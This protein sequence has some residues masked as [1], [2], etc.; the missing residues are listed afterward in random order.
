M[1]TSVFSK[2]RSAVLDFDPI[3]YAGT[4]TRVQ[5]MLVESRGPQAVVG[6]LCHIIMPDGSQ[7]YA[8]VVGLFGTTVQL[9][10]FSDVDGIELG[11]QVV[12]TGGTMKIA[13][14]DD[15]LGRVVDGLG[16]TIDGKGEVADPELY[17]VI[18]K[19][20][21]VLDR[22]RITQQI[23]TGIRAL[24]GLVPAG[25]GQR[26]GIFSG[27]GVGKSTLLGMIARNTNADVNVIALIGE[28]GREVREFIEQDLGPDGLE[29]SV[30]V[31]STSDTPAIARVRGAFVAMAVAE[32]FRD[33]KKDVML[34]F[35]SVTRFAWAQREIGLARGEAP[36]TRGY[37]PSVFSLLPR[38]L[39][40]CGTS[41]LGTITGFFTV[42]VEGDDLEEPV[43]DAVRGIL[44][45][46]VVL[47]R[48]LAQR[49][50][51]PAIDVLGSVSRL[52]TK[53]SSRPVRDAAGYVRR[54]LAIYAD[55]EDLITAG[56]Y[57]PG[58]SEEVDEA[59]K[60]LPRINAFLMQQIE[61]KA[62]LAETIR[63]LC[64]LA[65][66]E[67]PAEYAAPPEE[68]YPGEASPAAGGNGGEPSD[69][70]ANDA[71]FLPPPQSD[72]DRAGG[73]D[74]PM[75]D[76]ATEMNDEAL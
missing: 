22:K 69:A 64:D 39:E 62:D 57:V 12:A 68:P 59:I 53:V 52:E 19:P 15:L 50:H 20:P 47:A 38:I 42:L 17:P 73:A 67:V 9:M 3:K 27:S 16:R 54:M 28:R 26:L 49:Y 46:H 10:P 72:N 37:T 55:N 66:V 8:E 40:R 29:R 14:S 48:R 71:D 11:A 33:Q 76:N 41:E 63:R 36:S 65:E 44:D 1:A 4:V 5:G 43:S 45:G 51:Y 34:L 24:D 31:V 18:N 23:A 75:S 25:S 30:I 2:Y 74:Y 7:V 32:Y 35:D 21:H 56:V 70:A 60:K 6:E 61:E 58:S 13:V